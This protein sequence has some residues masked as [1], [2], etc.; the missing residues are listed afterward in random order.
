[1]NY[2]IK[3]CKTEN[4]I[5]PLK[6]YQLIGLLHQKQKESEKIVNT[7]KRKHFGIYYTDYSI[8]RLIA[9]RGLSESKNKDLLGLSFYEPCSGTGI[10]VIAYIDEVLGRIGNLNSKAFQKFIDQIYF[11]DIDSEAIDL[12]LKLLPLYTLSLNT[13][14]L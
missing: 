2:F 3:V 6:V 11:S 13:E 8:A 14:Y 1:M 4:K 10:F 5:D 12:L 9:K 7:D